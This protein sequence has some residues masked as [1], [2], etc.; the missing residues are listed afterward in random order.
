[1]NQTTFRV[2]KTE[3][4]AEGDTLIVLLWLS[5]KAELV[6]SEIPNK[7][8]WNK[9]DVEYYYTCQVKTYS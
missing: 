8:G 6:Q 2:K 3:L 9:Q 5:E 1:M 7:R 4:S